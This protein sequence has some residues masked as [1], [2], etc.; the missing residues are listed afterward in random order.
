LAN[1][2]STP[3][4]N[5]P[6]LGRSRRS[7]RKSIEPGWLSVAL[8]SCDAVQQDSK[9]LGEDEIAALTEASMNEDTSAALYLTPLR[10]YHRGMPK[11]MPPEVLEYLKG[12]GQQ[13]GKLGGKKA[14]KNMTA[15]ER[16]DRAK[17]ASDAAARKRTAARLARE[18]VI[19]RGKKA[20]R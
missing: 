18:A 10:C 17:K 7:G 16:S 1:L 11:R 5:F 13:Y 3:I 12:L 6:S 4:E 15:E 8:R 14:A 2:V 19:K 9:K 20:T